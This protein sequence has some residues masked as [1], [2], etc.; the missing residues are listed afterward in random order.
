[1]KILQ[2]DKNHSLIS[3]QLSEKG[4]LIEEDFVS[5]Y[6]DILVK[7]QGF[8]GIIIR[9]R[10]PLDKNFLEKASHLKFI[11][12]VG[13]GMENIDVE[14]AK[15]LNISLISSPEGNRDAVAE[16]VLGI[17]LVLLNRLFISS[18]EVKNGIWIREK[19]RGTEIKGKTF[20]IIGY[21]NM[22]K[23][24]AQRLSGFGV[25]VL[26][27]DVLPNLSNEFAKQVSLEEL[28]EK[29]D[30]L[31]LHLPYSEDS[32]YYINENFIS[33]MKKN[34]YLIN[35]ARGQHV[36]TKNLVESLKTGKILGAALDV[37][38]Y[39]KSSFEN[40][41]TEN[42]D[43]QYLLNSEKVLITPHIAGWTIESKEK[44]AQVIVDKIL[45]EFSV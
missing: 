41:E 20:G 40:I 11:A 12:R 6:K 2:L 25:E 35:T 1:M 13:A 43:L 9:S 18:Q 38:E 23:A 3:K 31:S 26:F 14:T 44:L 16:H 36:K 21:G 8:E 42:P 33:Q 17:L 4:F 39:E 29:A 10:I 32:K 27:H 37:L 30:F 34:F 19:N 5:S 24:V 45:E 7:I 28:Q 15:K 22:G